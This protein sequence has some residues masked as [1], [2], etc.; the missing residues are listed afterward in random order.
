MY[1]CFQ[2]SSS[3]PCFV[4]MR[5]SWRKVLELAIL[6]V[7]SSNSCLSLGSKRSAFFIWRFVL[8]MKSFTFFYLSF[9][10]SSSRSESSSSRTVPSSSSSSSIVSSLLFS[11][12]VWLSSLLDWMV[13]S[14]ISFLWIC[15][16]VRL[17]IKR[18]LDS[19]DLY[20]SSKTSTFS[21]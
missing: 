10:S 14:R 8:L 15:E 9:F 5:L 6:A 21:S 1:V 20:K 18:A 13:C 2:F 17:P 12:S 7:Y 16:A 11:S 4:E 19:V 3:S